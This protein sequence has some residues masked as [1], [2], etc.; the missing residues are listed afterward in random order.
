MI[1]YCSVVQIPSSKK[2]TEEGDGLQEGVRVNRGRDPLPGI[3][4]E[5]PALDLLRPLEHSGLRLP[6]H[7]RDPLSFHLAHAH[8]PLSRSFV[9]RLMLILAGGAT[10]Y[11]L[12]TRETKPNETEAATTTGGDQSKAGRVYG[13]LSLAA[14]ADLW[15]S[16][17]I[18]GH[19][20]RL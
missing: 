12:N 3:V 13:V 2:E 9:R 17:F 10:L 14:M 1:P 7:C 18:P 4:F 16:T 15:S 11:V 19:L 6:F 8:D 20:V 5:H